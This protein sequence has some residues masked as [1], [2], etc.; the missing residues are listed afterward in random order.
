MTA[1]ET[2]MT[3]L[4][5]LLGR[6][7]R[8]DG[9]NA[10]AIANV[11]VFRESQPHRPRALLYQ[12]YFIFVAQGK[13]QSVLD[14]TTYEYHAGQFLTVLTPMP[15]ACQVVEASCD[16]PLLALAIAVERRRI[17]DILLRME[18]AVP[19]GQR[20]AECNPSG[21][22]TAPLRERLLDAA[23]RLLEALESPDEAAI[24]GEAI[25]DEIYFR[26][27]KEERG[28]ALPYLLRQRGQIEQ[29]ARA[30]EHLHRNLEEVVSVGRLAGLVNM[31]SSAFHKK[32]KEVM[33]LSPLQYAKQVKLNHAQ[34]RLQQ[35][36]SVSEAGYSVGYNSPAQFSREYRRHYGVPPSSS[37]PL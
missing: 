1:Q 10:T 21:I 16:K 9:S 19:L 25:I 14:G 13:K 8:R 7:A 31:S 18:Q 29:I 4:V 23:I 35:G 33:H 11:E 12:P 26:I 2:K 34:A 36:M 17:L 6:N 20:A 22:F 5:E 24:V 37:R 32:F 15:V 3:R 30:V 28:G 27:L